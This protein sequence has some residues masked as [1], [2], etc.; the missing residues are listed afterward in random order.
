MEK[1]PI[2]LDYSITRDGRVYDKEGTE[3]NYYRNNDGYKTVS[4]KVNN[5]K[6]IT[7]GVHRLL[8]LTYKPCSDWM[9][10][11]VNHINGIKDCNVDDNVEWVDV[12]DNNSHAVLLNRDTKRPLIRSLKNGV[13][14]LHLTTEDAEEYFSVDIEQIWS[15]IKTGS[16]LNG[17]S[18]SLI[19]RGSPEAIAVVN[20]EL[21]TVESYRRKVKMLDLVDGVVKHY[22]SMHHAAGEFG[23]IVTFIRNRLSVPERPKI[24]DGRYVIVDEDKDF[25]H[26]TEEIKTRLLGR[27]KKDVYAYHI[28]TK[29]FSKYDSA[30]SF[31]KDNGLSKSLSL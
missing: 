5:G 3:R 12:K 26:I 28:P 10:K 16:L 18:L 30:S 8:A 21:G 4:V 1:I 13:K 19:K 2:A 27:G 29:Q 20:G 31:I 11:V 17:E 22:D 15:A 25:D 6:W 14:T 9:N 23:V 7:Y 24:F